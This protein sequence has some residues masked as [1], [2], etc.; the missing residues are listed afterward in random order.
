MKS[1][2]A[3][4]ALCAATT[5]IAQSS[6]PAPTSGGTT[7]MSTSAPS[8][9][10]NAVTTSLHYLDDDFGGN[11]FSAALDFDDVT[12][13]GSVVTV[14]PSGTVVSMDCPFQTAN[15]DYASEC[16]LISSIQYTFR[17]NTEYI[18]FDIATST[19]GQ[20]VRLQQA[21]TCVIG[22]NGN[23]M[24]CV[25]TVTAEAEGIGRQ[26]TSLTT[27]DSN[28]TEVPVIMTAGLEKLG[29]IPEGGNDGGNGGGDT[30]SAGAVRAAKT[31]GV[32]AFAIAVAAVVL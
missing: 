3:S 32:G 24:S 16:G 29:P 9:P 23:S 5:V 4:L 31:F 28:P 21:Q 26:T 22:D 10:T 25:A 14:N 13:Y 20:S 6:T 11:I 7:V 17:P 19:L 18:N 30:G 2:T 15:T 27:T 1:I 12:F 8:V